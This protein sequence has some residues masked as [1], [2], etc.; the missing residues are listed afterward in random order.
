MRVQTNQGDRPRTG[1]KKNYRCYNVLTDA[2]NPPDTI[3]LAPPPLPKTIASG[4][5]VYWPKAIANISGQLPLTLIDTHSREWESLQISKVPIR[6][7]KAMQCASS[8]IS[9]RRIRIY[10]GTRSQHPAAQLERP[11]RH[12]FQIVREPG[13]FMAFYSTERADP[14]ALI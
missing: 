3:L 2:M 14:F 5:S 6:V 12:S 13:M 11:A 9:L 4:G 10:C 1:Y 8:V 7:W